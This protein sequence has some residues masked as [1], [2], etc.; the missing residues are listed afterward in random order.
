MSQ[1]A[2]V[3]GSE[4]F[5]NTC[6]KA[7]QAVKFSPSPSTGSNTKHEHEKSFPESQPVLHET[8][9]CEMTKQMESPKG[10]SRIHRSPERSETETVSPESQTSATVKHQPDRY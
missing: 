8:P 10:M 3:A 6:S 7:G 5:T 2:S 4:M 1:S 9:Q